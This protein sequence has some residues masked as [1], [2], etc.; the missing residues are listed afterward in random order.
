MKKTLAVL[1]CILMAVSCSLA[2]ADSAQK[3]DYTVVTVNGA[4]SI[5]GITPEGYHLADTQNMDTTIWASFTSDDPSKPYFD[6]IISFLEEYANVGRLNDLS[7]EEATSRPFFDELTPVY[8]SRRMSL[9][10]QS[11]PSVPSL[12]LIDLIAPLG[13]GQRAL[14]LCPPDTGKRELMADYARMICSNYPDVT[15]LILLIDITPEDV[16]AFRESVP[17]PVLAST[18]DQAPE[19]HLRAIAGMEQFRNP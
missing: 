16:T 5:R 2:A 7:E 3:E 19:A 10:A 15:V 9:E 13:F 18:F 17:C 8:P 11:G 6:L 14:L 1:M 4:F 12:R